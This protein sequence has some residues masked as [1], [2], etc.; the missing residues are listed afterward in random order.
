[1]RTLGMV[2]A[3][4]LVVGVLAG[5]DSVQEV[6]DTADRANTCVK[7]LEAAGYQPNLND[8]AGSAEKAHQKAEELRKLAEET[9]DA[10][11]RQKLR[12]SADSLADVKATDLDPARATD[13]LARNARLVKNITETCGN[14]GG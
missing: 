10:D 13:W 12:D 6:A 14:V 8:P 4:P 2:A 1:M 9:K 3:L 5:C 7:A 11:L